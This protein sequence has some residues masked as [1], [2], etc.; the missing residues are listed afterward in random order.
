M[1]LDAHTHA[2]PEAGGMGP[3]G[4]ARLPALLQAMDAAGVAGALLCAEAVDVPYIR[5]ISNAFVAECCRAHP[6]RLAGFASVHPAA[7]D[8][9]PVFEH[10]VT[11]LGLCGLKLHPRFQGVPASDPR[12]VA[13]AR[14]AVDLGVPVAIDAMLWKPTPLRLQH[15]FHVDDL[16]KAV[17]E[18]RV[19]LCHAGGF[20]FLD[21]LA[22]AVAN[23]NVFLEVAT[24]LPYFCGTPFEDQFVF[25]LKQAGAARVLWGS[26]HPQKDMGDALALCDE[27]LRNHGFGDEERALVF[28]GTLRALLPPGTFDQK[29]TL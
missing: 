25:V 28:G 6:D 13:L 3:G 18:A 15:V 24:I 8:A 26:D 14:R 27:T 20:H 29:D 10:A 2:H 19:I 23:D 17:P 21:A 5:P 12:V 16:C 4:D 9:L 11:G 7:A 1:I 22:V